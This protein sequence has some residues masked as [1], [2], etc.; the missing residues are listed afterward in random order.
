MGDSK[1]TL[2]V[3]Q[4]VF[5]AAQSDFES[6]LRHWLKD[7][8][9][10]QLVPSPDLEDLIQN[11][12]EN[13]KPRLVLIDGR[14]ESTRT[15]ELT[16]SLKM[17][18]NAPVVVFYDATTQLNFSVLKKNGADGVLH[19]HFDSEFI[20][21][22]LLDLTTWSE[23]SSPP[24]SL[25][26]PLAADDLSEE[27]DLNFDLYVHLPGNQKSLLVRRRGQT[28]DPKLIEKV[29][30]SHQ[31]LYFKK[32][33]MKLFL[34]Y[35]RT[36]LSLRNSEDRMGATDKVLRTRQKIWEIISQFFDQ[37]ATDFKGGKIILENCSLILKEF[38]IN[39]WKS[40]QEAF[41]TLV[42]ASG[43]PRSFYND[44]MSLCVYAGVLGYF[45]EKKPEE[46]QDLAL[47]GLLHNVGLAT[48]S[49]P[50]LDPP[51]EELSENARKEYLSYPE[52]SVNII[53]GKKVPLNSRVTELIWEHREK[54][55]GNGF[56]KGTDNSTHHGDSGL[57]QFA[58]VLLQMTQLEKNQAKHTLKGAFDHL[59][60]QLLSGQ[61]KI[62]SSILLALTQKL[63]TFLT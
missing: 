57:F 3:N 43:R 38:E 1:P 40:P 14:G 61:S 48:L 34:E 50:V 47:A 53:K 59:N 39:Q 22:K 44:A 58:Y 46:I 51:L 5:A 33:Q 52:R 26:N 20:M 24:I 56:P 18:F 15:L 13:L 4:V 16:Q 21:D 37:E 29:K 6:R 55:G 35:S 10:L 41:K 30:S 60:Q 28:V 31:N 49:Q 27:M 7:L 62:D 45:L 11:P 23:D 2:E 36:L 42:Q 19:I 17:A 12:P 54:P 9:Q 25:L 8:S 32:T 63:K